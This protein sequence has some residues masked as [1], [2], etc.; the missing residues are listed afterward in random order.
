[1][2]AEGSGPRVSLTMSKLT[3]LINGLLVMTGMPLVSEN[4]HY[5]NKRLTCD[6]EDTCC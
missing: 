1:M 3:M 4:Y 6:E 5:F 2:L